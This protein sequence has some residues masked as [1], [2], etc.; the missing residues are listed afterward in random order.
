[1]VF[2]EDDL[3]LNVKEIYVKWNYKSLDKS[4]QFDDLTIK[5]I[6]ILSLYRP[7]LC[8]HLVYTQ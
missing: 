4:K 6:S 3:Y 5:C 7:L 1:M 2:V 8:D